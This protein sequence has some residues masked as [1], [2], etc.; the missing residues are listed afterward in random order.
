[1]CFVHDS[2]PPIAPLEGGALDARDRKAAGFADASAAAWAET[3]AFVRGEGAP[4]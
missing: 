2:R 4:A 1:M 3:L